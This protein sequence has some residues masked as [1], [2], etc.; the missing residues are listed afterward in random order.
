MAIRNPIS[1]ARE[2]RQHQTESEA[3]LWQLLRAKQLCRLKFRRQHPEPP[4]I[5]DFACTKERFAVEIDGEYHDDQYAKEQ[6]RE[7]YLVRLGWQIIRFTNDD[8][9]KM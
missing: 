9:L 4:F 8:V 6:E 1:N 7:Q 2:L 3:I 5:L